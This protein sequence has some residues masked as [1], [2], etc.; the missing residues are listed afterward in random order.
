LLG[1]AWTLGS[2]KY[3]S[4]SG[5]ESG[6]WFETVGWRGV[7]EIDERSPLPDQFPSLPGSVFP[8]YHVLADFGEFRSGEIVPLRS[9]D[10]LKV[11]GCLLQHEN[12]SA[13]LVANLSD[14]QQEVQ[15]TW[16]D[17]PEHLSIRLLDETTA[18]RAMTD[19]E[20]FRADS[21]QS[22]HHQAGRID[23]RL[24]PFAIA[25]IDSR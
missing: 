10:P 21:G 22:L 19:P 20:T 3:I 11:D 4:E 8:L 25:R 14:D 9:T 18:E 15:I 1:A 7:M 6:T 13:L 16:P 23:L 5:V 24:R 2:L 12:R 17:A